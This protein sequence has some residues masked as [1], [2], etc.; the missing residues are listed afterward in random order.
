M[1][2][3]IIALAMIDLY[4][5]RF[6]GVGEISPTPFLGNENPLFYRGSKSFCQLG[7]FYLTTAIINSN[8]TNYHQLII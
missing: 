2:S 4:D 5:F 3:V 7:R 1:N 6:Y 8:H